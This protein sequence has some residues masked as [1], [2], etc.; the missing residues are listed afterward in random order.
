MFAVSSYLDVCGLK[1][2]LILSPR[3]AEGPASCEVQPRIMVEPCASQF[4]FSQMHG[5]YVCVGGGGAGLVGEVS[6]V[7]LCMVCP[8]EQSILLNSE[9]LI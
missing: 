7:I 3:E 8:P 1:Q 5:V 2:G 9:K 4:L 6:P